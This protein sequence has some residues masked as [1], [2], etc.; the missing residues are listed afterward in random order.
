[1]SSTMTSGGVLR[2]GLMLVLVVAV[3]GGGVYYFMSHHGE[4]KTE[5]EEKEAVISVKMVNPR[6]DKSFVVTEKRPADVRP[7]F[8][9]ALETMVPGYVEWMPYD[10]GSQVTKGE[11]LIEVSVPDRVERFNQRKA[12]VK[13][14]E[15]EVDQKIAAVVTAEADL[16][17]AK[18][19]VDAAKAR[20]VSSQAYE[21]FRLQQKDRYEKL[22]AE[23]A[24]EGQLVDEQMDR[25]EASK[26]TTI[27]DKA[28][29]QFAQAEVISADARVKQAKA[30][31]EAAKSKV[32]VA[33]A[34]MKYA[35]VMVDY[36]TIRAPYDGEITRRNV[37]P[38]YFVQNAG[39]GHA[40]PLL[41]VQRN[42]I[43][44]IVVRVP[45]NYAPYI[46]P[47][48]EAIF[49]TPIMPGVKIHGK[50]TRYPHSLVNPE[51]DRT[52][53]VEVD[54]WNRKSAEF[55]QKIQDKKFLDS[56]K[57][58]L[59]GDPKGGLP[60]VPKFEGKLKPGQQKQLLPGMFGE[61]TLILQKFADVH[62]L[63]SSA[64]VKRGGY[65]YIYVVKDG[66][67]HLQ[68]I[69]VDIDDGKLARVELLSDEG[70]SL[71]DL[72]GDEN[73]IVSNQGELSEGQAVEPVLED[74]WKK[75]TPGGDKNEKH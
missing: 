53:L 72:K 11:K 62:M 14:T 32:A 25:Y 45:D 16:E 70:E 7:Y 15:A 60:V 55:A 2:T 8:E 49:E 31:L 13:R 52:M 22:Y 74:D 48:T 68:P 46:T 21:H 35:K 30:D 71:G 66:K 54:L 34:E 12:D 56:L 44:T 33:N 24:I 36:G 75:L 65:D 39:D 23:R 29:W 42:D 64:V 63:P 37:N 57:K 43:V 69:K 61:M 1:M 50:V 17:A 67:A 26:Q 9:T 20:Y 10:V 47:T 38:G 51:R 27:A 41:V 40:T 59:P 6:Y 19:K 18:A 28:A 5:T 58:G 3:I 4:A 73:V